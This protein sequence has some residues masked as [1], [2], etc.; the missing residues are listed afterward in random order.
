MDNAVPTLQP[1]S[2]FSAEEDQSQE[3]LETE[4]F[5]PITRPTVSK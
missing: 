5:V 1:E 3:E 4:L 2:Y